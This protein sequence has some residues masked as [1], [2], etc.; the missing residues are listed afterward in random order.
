MLYAGSSYVKK[1]MF[2]V[3]LA[4]A[5]GDIT[6]SDHVVWR[7][8]ARTPYVPSPLLYGEWLYFLNHYQG[9]LARVHAKTG[10]EP[11]RPMRL[12]GMREIYASPVAAAGR[13]YITDRQGATL[14]IS[15]GKGQPKML[16]H[17]MLD[18]SFSASA[19]IVGT[20]IY[21]RGMRYLYC[22]AKPVKGQ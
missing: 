8:G 19:A 20:E 1:R 15:H 7:R 13:I 14:V 17:N 2:A 22:I 5:K 18:D 3:R 11:S 9:F 6:N 21:L 16:A 4:G 10:K 12:P